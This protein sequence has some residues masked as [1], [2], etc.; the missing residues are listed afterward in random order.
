MQDLYDT[1]ITRAILIEC[2]IGNTAQSDYIKIPVGVRHEKNFYLDIITNGIVANSN[3][4]GFSGTGVT[5]GLSIDS[6]T[7]VIS[8]VLT[9]VDGLVR[10]VN[11]SLLPSM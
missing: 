2:R 5:V 11:V 7:G 3:R 9:S 1:Y 6:S 10:D 4:I 8:V